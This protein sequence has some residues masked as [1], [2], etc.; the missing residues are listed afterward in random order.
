VKNVVR[1]AG[2]ANDPQS[3]QKYMVDVLGTLVAE[4]DLTQEQLQKLLDSASAA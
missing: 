2:K 4:K 3:W 1:K